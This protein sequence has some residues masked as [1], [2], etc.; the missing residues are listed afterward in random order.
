DPGRGLAFVHSSIAARSEIL[1]LLCYA[2][3]EIFQCVKERCAAI[4]PH[5]CAALCMLH[6]TIADAIFG[7]SNGSK[8][9]SDAV[10]Q[11]PNQTMPALVLMLPG[12]GARKDECHDRTQ[13]R[14]GQGGKSGRSRHST[15]RLLAV[16]AA[17]VRIAEA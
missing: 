11:E 9:R 4:Q 17:E 7:L 5:C 15:V 6:C 14:Q 13:H 10:A 8:G 1:A 12:M 16:R 2:K 3:N